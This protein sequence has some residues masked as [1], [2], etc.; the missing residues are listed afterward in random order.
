[1]KYIME[2]L[3]PFRYWTLWISKKHTVT[4]YHV[5]TVYSDM[6][7]H[8]DGMMRALAKKKTHEKK[9]L[10]FAVKLALQKLSKYYAEVTPTMSMLLIP[11]D[12]LNHFWKLRSF[13]KL[14]RAMDIHPEDETSYTTQFQVAVLKNVENE[15]DAKHQGVPDNKLKSLPISNLV[16]SA[17]AS[18]SSQSSF[19]PYD[20][21]SDDKESLT[22]N[23]VAKTTPGQS[24]RVSR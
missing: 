12:I 24:D 1:M 8:M 18:G 13:R 3:R 22:P 23:D 7:D 19:D 20:M 14:D 17:M 2:V 4:L 21:S 11:A 10:F 16:P 5:I 6:F 15:Y 9:D